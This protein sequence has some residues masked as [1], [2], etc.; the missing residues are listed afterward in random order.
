MR[1]GFDICTDL[2]AMSDIG[3]G[4]LRGEVERVHNHTAECYAFMDG[5]KRVRRGAYI[6]ARDNMWRR[7]SSKSWIELPE[8]PKEQS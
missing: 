2:H 4:H 5:R 3:S 7:V 1:I 8:P 6:I